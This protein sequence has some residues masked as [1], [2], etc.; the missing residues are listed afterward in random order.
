MYVLLIPKRNAV[1]LFKV[2]NFAMSDILKVLPVNKEG[3]LS[4]KRVRAGSVAL[5]YELSIYY[6]EGIA[7]SG[8]LLSQTPLNKEN[9]FK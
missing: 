7:F 4:P 5:N 6:E 8:I 9:L 1:F 2:L 3:L